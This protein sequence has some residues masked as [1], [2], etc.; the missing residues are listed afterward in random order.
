MVCLILFGHQ[1]RSTAF[2]K[3]V[4]FGCCVSPCDFVF[5]KRCLIWLRS[6][7]CICSN[8]KSTTPRFQGIVYFGR[9]VSHYSFV[10]CKICLIKSKSV[11]IVYINYFWPR[12]S[13][14][15]KL[16]RYT[17]TNI[18]IELKDKSLSSRIIYHLKYIKFW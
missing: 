11:S 14:D 7:S 1:V 13:I 6:V 2:L 15:A 10:F 4:N 12:L 3:I 9:C 18:Y 17:Q 8:L 5:C 16:F